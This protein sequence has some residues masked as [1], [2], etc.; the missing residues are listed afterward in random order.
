MIPCV[1]LRTLDT[2]YVETRKEISEAPQRGGFHPFERGGTER[3][4]LT[5]TSL[6]QKRCRLKRRTGIIEGMKPELTRVRN[7]VLKAKTSGT[8]L[9]PH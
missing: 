8:L 3:M 4:R 7:E 5:S 2:P 9:G 1:S 6:E